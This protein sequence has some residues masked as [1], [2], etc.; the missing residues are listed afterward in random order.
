MKFK[1]NDMLA[2]SQRGSFTQINFHAIHDEV[3]NLTCNCFKDILDI[4]RS[5]DHCKASRIRHRPIP[6]HLCGTPKDLDTPV[7]LQKSRNHRILL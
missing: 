4:L 2:E 1:I 7:I 5:R 3:N 6:H